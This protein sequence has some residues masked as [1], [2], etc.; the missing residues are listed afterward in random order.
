M[1]GIWLLYLSLL[2][3]L[4]RQRSGHKRP[5]KVLVLKAIPYETKQMQVLYVRVSQR[6]SKMTFSKKVIKLGGEKPSMSISQ[7]WVA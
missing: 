6:E 1:S 3:I 4:F 2:A 7:V 5:Q